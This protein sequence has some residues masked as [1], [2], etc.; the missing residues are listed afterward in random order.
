VHV[1]RTLKTLRREGLI[2]LQGTQIAI[3]D[4]RRLQASADFNP[5]Y[6]AP[7]A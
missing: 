5:G 1:N 7:M 3:P 4:W 2:V 6:L